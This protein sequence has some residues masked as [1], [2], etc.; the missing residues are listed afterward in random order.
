MSKVFERIMYTQIESFMEDK[1]SKL[2]TGFKK[3]HIAQNCLINMLEKRKNTLDKDGF[4]CAMFIDLSKAF[5]TMNHDLLGI[6]FSKRCTFFHEK[7]P[8]E[9]T[10]ASSCK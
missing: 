8:N 2:L 7:L 3:N 9:K 5:D 4:V 10:T 1:L 6:W